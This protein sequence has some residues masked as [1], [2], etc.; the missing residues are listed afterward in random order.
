M[1][2]D[3]LITR[4]YVPTLKDQVQGLTIVRALQNDPIG[5]TL[6]ATVVLDNLPATPN[7]TAR[8]I[9]G[10]TVQATPGAAQSVVALVA[11]LIRNGV[12]S[13]RLQKQPEFAIGAAVQYSYT[14]LDVG[15][16]LLPGDVIQLGAQFSAGAAAN[17]VFGCAWG[18]DI[19]RANIQG[20]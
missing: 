18:V 2:R 16:I 8:L 20:G 11:N 4:L 5:T 7:D 3:S 9:E 6:A 14:F 17:L 1:S 12:F 19:P 10:V 15:W 13:G